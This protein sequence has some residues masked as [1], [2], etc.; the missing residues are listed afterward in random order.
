MPGYPPQTCVQGFRFFRLV[1]ILVSWTLLF[2]KPICADDGFSDLFRCGDLSGWVVEGR[3]TFTDKDETKPVW[4]V[5]NG[6]VRCA[7]R[8]FGFLRFD[9]RLSDFTLHVEYRMSDG[10]NSGIGIRGAR[11]SG[12]RESRPS[13]AGYE[14]Q[15]LDDS[16]QPPS[17]KSSAALCRYVAPTQNAARPA[18]EWNVMD[19]VCVGPS[20]R[21]TLNDQIVQDID[22]TEIPSIRDKPLHGYLS[23]Q[24]HGGRIEFRKVRLKKLCSQTDSTAK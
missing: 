10:C 16:G 20:I 8:G 22:Q 7:G 18:G 12:S 5:E 4:T 3:G 9:S 6:I 13:F 1:L 11:F 15:I 14:I 24:N 19:V 21:V 2:A 17:M 23:L